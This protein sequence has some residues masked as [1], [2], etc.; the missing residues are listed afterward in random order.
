MQ[1]AVTNSEHEVAFLQ[2]RQHMRRHKHIG[3]KDGITRKTTNMTKTL[4]T[5]NTLCTVTLKR[6]NMTSL[7]ASIITLSYMAVSGH[8]DYHQRYE[9]LHRIYCISQ[10]I[11][12]LHIQKSVLKDMK[13]FTVSTVSP[14]TFTIC[15][16]KTQCWSYQCI[17]TEIYSNL[18]GIFNQ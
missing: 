7:N 5:M 6:P 3:P 13:S 4:N 11:H 15:I 17:G 18:Q 9:I 16:F 12:N 1:Q 10:N 8:H 2:I 14:K